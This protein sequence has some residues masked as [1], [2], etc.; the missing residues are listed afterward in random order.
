[1]GENKTKNSSE[2]AGPA[3]LYG[4]CFHM[5]KPEM[6]LAYTTSQICQ[7]EFECT[8]FDM[9]LSELSL[10]SPVGHCATCML[11]G[12]SN[13]SQARVLMSLS[14]GLFMFLILPE[15]ES[16]FCHSCPMWAPSKVHTLFLVRKERL[17]GT[18]HLL[19]L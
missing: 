5:T 4:R 16:A 3:C 13:S 9:C 10:P 8:V 19:R 7:Q 12:C 1:M 18:T 14:A 15:C 6:P 2:C 11:H 17:P